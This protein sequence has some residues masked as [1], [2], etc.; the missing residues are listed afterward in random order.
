MCQG[1]AVG[2]LR[3]TQK[4]NTDKSGLTEP[5]MLLWSYTAIATLDALYTEQ[6]S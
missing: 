4:V 5:Q 3:M 6:P 2:C 1:D